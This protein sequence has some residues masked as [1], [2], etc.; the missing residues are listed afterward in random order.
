MNPSPLSAALILT[1]Y[2]LA[3]VR[4]LTAAKPIWGTVKSVRWITV[5]IPAIIVGAGTV[6]DALKDVT[7]WTDVIVALVTA[8]GAGFAASRG[9]APKPPESGGTVIREG[10]LEQ[11]AQE[12]PPSLPGVQLLAMAALL[13]VSCASSAAEHPACTP[14]E[15]EKTKLA[16]EADVHVQCA[17]V[18]VLE[19]CAAYPK[20]KADF[21]RNVNAGC[22]L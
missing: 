22:G 10:A 5:A 13:L 4:L 7:T 21:E 14:A 11:P 18:D 16:Y 20:L 8:V 9:P 17:A 3:A 2:A 6:P 1:G 15:L 19:E 12:D